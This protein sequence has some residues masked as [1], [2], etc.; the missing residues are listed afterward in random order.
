MMAQVSENKKLN[1][2]FQD[3]FDP[4]GSEI[5]LKPVAEYIEPEKPVNFYSVVE[6]AKN[7]NETAIGYRLAQ[8]SRTPSLSYGIHLN[9]DKTVKVIFS[10]HD[11]VIV[12]ADK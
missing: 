5:Y 12:L 4:E 11:K 8:D 7:R 3:I 1:S 6:S 10:S 9:P 2:V